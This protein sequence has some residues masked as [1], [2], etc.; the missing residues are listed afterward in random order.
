MAILQTIIQEKLQNLIKIWGTGKRLD[1]KDKKFPV[2]I[3]DIQKL[4]KKDSIGISVFGHENKEKYAIY[5][6][7]KCCQ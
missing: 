1:F 3:R 5:A 2:E 7:R 4:E 6:L